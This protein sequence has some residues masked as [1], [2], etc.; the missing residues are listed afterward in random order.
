[1]QTRISYAPFPPLPPPL[2]SQRQQTQ[3]KS[4]PGVGGALMKEKYEKY[5]AEE[6]LSAPLLYGS[7]IL[8]KYEK[9]MT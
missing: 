8:H 5:I 4:A 6:V 3:R 9:I 1:M 2:L 7:R